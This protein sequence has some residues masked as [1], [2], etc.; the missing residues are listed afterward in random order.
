MPRSTHPHLNLCGTFYYLCSILDGASRAIVH[1]E[2]REQMTEA[3]RRGAAGV[4]SKDLTGNALVE[5]LERILAARASL[6]R[7]RGPNPCLRSADM[8]RAGSTSTGHRA[9][10]KSYGCSRAV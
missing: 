9:R 10:S 4:V 1:W 6:H 5:A 2:I 8:A 7:R 3:V